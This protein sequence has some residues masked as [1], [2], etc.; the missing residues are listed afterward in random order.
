MSN[1]NEDR[2]DLITIRGYLTHYFN[3]IMSVLYKIIYH[4]VHIP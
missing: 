2:I 4:S 3:V 1:V